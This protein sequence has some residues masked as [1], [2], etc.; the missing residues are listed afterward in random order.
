MCTSRSCRG[1]TPSA[2]NSNKSTLLAAWA[3]EAAWSLTHTHINKCPLTDSLSE[4]DDFHLLCLISDTNGQKGSQN[5]VN[6]LT[7]CA[8]S[9]RNNWVMSGCA[10]MIVSGHNSPIISNLF[11]LSLSQHAQWSKHFCFS[12]P[13]LERSI[14]LSARWFSPE[15]KNIFPSL[16]GQKKKKGLPVLSSRM[17]TTRQSFTAAEFVSKWNIFRSVHIHLSAG[18]TPLSGPFTSSHLSFLLPI[19]ISA[20]HHHSGRCVL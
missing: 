13:E 17:E 9:V 1:S 4:S 16:H 20:S 19:C 14:F 15:I 18:S 11:S 2:C 12:L 8:R 7:H 5:R 10:T 3:P 6:S